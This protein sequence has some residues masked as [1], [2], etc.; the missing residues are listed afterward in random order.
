MAGIIDL[1]QNFN[2]NLIAPPNAYQPEKPISI[3]DIL[4]A[5]EDGTFT[6]EMYDKYLANLSPKEA[7]Q[8]AYRRSE[9]SEVGAEDYVP[10]G[11][12]LKELKTINRKEFTPSYVY[13]T[14]ILGKPKYDKTPQGLFTDS[15]DPDSTKKLSMEQ[16]EREYGD[17]RQLLLDTR[18]DRLDFTNDLVFNDVISPAGN[19]VL[20]MILKYIE[21]NDLK[22]GEYPET[23]KQLVSMKKP[24]GSA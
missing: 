5:Q 24:L 7:A 14:N 16:I 20:N 6:P 8:R 22:G 18:A 1:I 11:D 15:Y 4:A 17:L 12:F 23:F 19:D 10:F 9:K 13:E 21:T 3:Q 2:N